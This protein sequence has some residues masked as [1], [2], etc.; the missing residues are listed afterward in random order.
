MSFIALQDDEFSNI[1]GALVWWSLSKDVDLVDL[2]EALEVQELPL[3]WLPAAPKLET[4]AQRAGQSRITNKRQLLRPLSVRGSYD[5]V[6]EQVIGTGQDEQLRHIPRV[7]VRVIENEGDLKTID[8]TPMTTADVELAR[9]IAAAVSSFREALVPSDMSVWLV[10][11]LETRV[12]AVSLRDRGGFYFVPAGEPLAL[13]RRIVKAVHASSFH[14]CSLIPALR[15]ADAVEAILLAVRREAEKVLNDLETYLAG[16]VSTRGLNAHE[17]DIQAIQS[18]MAMYAKLLNASL[19]D[20]EARAES[21]TGSIL[22][23][24]AVR[25][26]L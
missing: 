15:S 16:D 24:R 17:R 22:A 9:E 3:D 18:K 26:T 6:D 20:L 23:A 4:V 25:E 8:V 19:P 7:R 10:W 11:L 12:R 14:R 5:F 2:R 21:L 13:W 1:A